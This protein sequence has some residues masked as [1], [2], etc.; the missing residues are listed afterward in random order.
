M[1]MKIWNNVLTIT[2]LVGATAMMVQ[3]HWEHATIVGGLGAMNS[4]R[5]IKEEK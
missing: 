1:N 3:G 4:F 5:Y 2:L